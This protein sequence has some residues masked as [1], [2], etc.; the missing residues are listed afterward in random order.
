MV[1]IA[2]GASGRVCFYNSRNSDFEFL[3]E[4]RAKD[5][6]PNQDNKPKYRGIAC[7]LENRLYVTD[8][9]NNCVIRLKPI[10]FSEETPVVLTPTPTPEEF[11]PYGGVGYP[12]R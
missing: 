7:D 11:T 1:A 4:W 10:A 3:S 6:I 8:I 9:Q 5:D 2:D 12:I